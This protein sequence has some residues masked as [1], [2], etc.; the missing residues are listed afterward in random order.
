[1]FD[2]LLEI[3][4][5]WVVLPVGIWR[6]DDRGP[7][8]LPHRVVADDPLGESSVVCASESVD[9]AEAVRHAP[10]DIAW[11]IREVRELRDERD[12]LKAE[13]EGKLLVGKS[14]ER[15]DVTLATYKIEKPDDE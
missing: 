9:V 14:R 13:A 2:R 12:A 11:L 10:D 8:A 4:R 15:G 5:R 6:S 1:M 7:E 3:E